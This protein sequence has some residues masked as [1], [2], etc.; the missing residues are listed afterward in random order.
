MKKGYTRVD[1]NTWAGNMKAVPLYKKIGMMWNPEVS[2]V[3]MEDYIPG[4]LKHPLCSAFFSPLSGADDWY[5]V[6]VREPVQAPDE[7]NHKGLAVFPYEFAHDENSLSVVVDRIGRGITAIDSTVEEKRLRVEAR[8]NS[9][10]VLCGMPY[11]YTLEVQNGGDSPIEASIQLIGF[12]GLIFDADAKKK[13]E[14]NPG[15][16]LSWE[17]PFHLDST[18]ELFRDGVKGSNI[19]TQLTIGGAKSELYTGLKVKPAV[20]LMTRWGSCRVAPGGISS[21][22]V[23]IVSNMKEMAKAQVKIDSMKVPLTVENENGDV[24]LS[25]EGLGGTTL[26]IIAG[27]DLEEGTHDLWVSFELTPKN[28]QTVITRKFRIPVFCLG[29]RGLG[30]GYDDKQRRLIIASTNYSATYAIEGAI[31]RANDPYGEDAFSLQV[32]S[33][34]G[35]PF[36]INP[37][38]FAEREHSVSSTESE[39]VIS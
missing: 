10:Q 21:I 33:A 36:G 17:V 25:P 18:A 37:F 35:P 23:T 26:Q 22:P 1:L 2:G 28:G 39:T 6:H 16:I 20:E 32:R 9:H 4:I 15:E 34:I 14:I 13:E 38:R 27:D 5:N 8:V 12:K 19:I 3:Q 29:K 24:S 7:F 31:L 30:V 11:V